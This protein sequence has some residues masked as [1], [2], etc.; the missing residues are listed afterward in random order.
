MEN[1]N[2]SSK[3]LPIIKNDWTSFIDI[4]QKELLNMNNILNEDLRRIKELDKLINKLKEIINV[5]KDNP[6][7]ILEYQELFT[8]V[9]SSLASSFE[10]LRFFKEN[11]NFDN[12]AVSVI[13]NRIINSLNIVEKID[14]HRNL[15]IKTQFLRER[16]KRIQSLLRGNI[17]DFDL[18][19]ELVDK[20]KVTDEVK[21]NIIAYPFIMLAV[22]QK[23]ITDKKDN[24]VSLDKTRQEEQIKKNKE[25]FD[26]ICQKYHDM[27]EKYKNLLLLCFE[28]RKD[29]SLDEVKMYSNYINDSMELLTESFD[30]DAISKIVVLNLFKVKKDVENIIAGIQDMVTDNSIDLKDEL[31]YLDEMIK[32]FNETIQTVLKFDYDKNGDKVHEKNILKTFFALDA[33]NRLLIDKDLLIDNQSSVIAL[34]EKIAGSVNAK[35]EGA[36]TNHMLGVS[37]LEKL[38]EK[39]ISMITSSK[40]MLA[41]IVVDDS[42]LIISGT[43]AGS[44]KFNH[45]II[46]TVKRN[47]VSIRRQ[48]ELIKHNDL[49]YVE[50]QNSI[51]K[52]II[53]DDDE[54]TM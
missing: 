42:V 7:L 10:A 19:N 5:S 1:S 28:V 23:E 17:I 13:Y 48:I 43:L 46:S 52:T 45:E 26:E 3:I 14:E 15:T 12:S 27:K 20:L 30:K 9:D 35:I 41:Y 22:R 8:Y 44:D 36:R 29:L 34:I 11:D 40:I 18:I 54:K 38:L 25:R 53:Q 32:E 16:M 51:L 31:D 47:I 33:F 24:T 2:L 21:K 39:N 49:D 50:L 6:E 37:D 4:L